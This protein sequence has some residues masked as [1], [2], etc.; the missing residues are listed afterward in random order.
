M[1]KFYFS[2]VDG[3]DRSSVSK[4]NKEI[5]NQYESDILRRIKRSEEKT[6]S[7]N[8]YIADFSPEEKMRFL[9]L[10]KCFENVKVYYRFE[11]NM[12]CGYLIAV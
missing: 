6:V 12:S 1:G 7:I 11:K 10:V 3:F 8:E 4:R 5:I 2:F 9:G